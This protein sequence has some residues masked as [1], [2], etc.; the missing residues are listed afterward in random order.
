MGLEHACGTTGQ[1]EG[2]NDFSTGCSDKVEANVE[3]EDSIRV[4]PNVC[5]NV[6]N[7][8]QRMKENVP[9]G[10]SEMKKAATTR[11]ERKERGVLLLYFLF[12]SFPK[13]S[14]MKC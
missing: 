10:A 3:K 7:R 13:G 4:V 12:T 6:Q 2:S 9:V 14:I 5:K 8:I 1:Y 11:T